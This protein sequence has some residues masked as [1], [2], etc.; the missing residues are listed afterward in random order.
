MLKKIEQDYFKSINDSL[1]EFKALD[2]LYDEEKYRLITN[3]NEMMI[4]DLFLKKA[5]Y[6]QLLDQN[7]NKINSPDLINLYK[8]SENIVDDIFNHIKNNLEDDPF[9]DEYI[10]GEIF[11]Y[12][13]EVGFTFD[14][15]DYEENFEL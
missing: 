12:I 15:E 5:I 11:E 2:N 14:K 9:K 3:R 4:N 10:H 7:N 8:D 1:N 13:Y 6:L